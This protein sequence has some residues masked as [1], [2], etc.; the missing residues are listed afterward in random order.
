M[1]KSRA[2]ANGRQ[3]PNAD[4]TLR[5]HLGGEGPLPLRSSAS[6]PPNPQPTSCPGLVYS[7]AVAWFC[8]ALDFAES[9]SYKIVGTEC[10]RLPPHPSLLTYFSATIYA[11]LN[12]GLD[13]SPTFAEAEAR[14][15]FTLAVSAENNL[16][17]ISEKL[18]NFAGGKAK[19]LC[20]AMGHL[21]QATL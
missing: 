19:R 14:M 21:K 6:S 17:T 18:A 7:A 4:T 3:S 8:S 20:T 15:S 11:R 12:G 13:S 1:A 5:T 9:I 16:V 10:E 2:A